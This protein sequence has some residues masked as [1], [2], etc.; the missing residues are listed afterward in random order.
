MILYESMKKIFVVFLLISLWGCDKTPESAKSQLKC[1]PD[2]GGL[3]LPDGFCALVVADHINFLRHI[4][5][6]RNGDIYGSRRNL[7]F[8]AGGLVGIRDLDDDGK[9]DVI[10][11]FGNEPGLGIAIYEGFLY[12]GTDKRI[13]KYALDKPDLVPAEDPEIV[14]DHFPD[15]KIH[16]GKTFAID[17][18]GLMYINVGS[19]SNACQ[20]KEMIPG[21]KGIDPCPD[22]KQ[23]AAI[24]RFNAKLVNQTFPTDGVKYATGIRNTY[25]IS[26]NPDNDTL[27]AV[28]HGRDGL[29]DLWPD[30][31]EAQQGAELPAEEFLMIKEKDIFGWPYCYYDPNKKQSKLAPEYGG[32]GQKTGR[33]ES[34]KA[35]V[36]AFPAH[37]SPNDLLF[38]SGDQFPQEFQK[39]AFIAFHGSYNRG[40][41]EQVGYQVV[42]VP[43]K[44]GLPTGKT[45]VFADGFSGSNLIKAPEDAEFRPGGLAQGPDGSL[46]IADSVQGRIWRIL[47]QANQN[48]E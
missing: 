25:A 28:Q 11:E 27:Y 5:V 24:W 20:E 32:D 8:E 38:Y 41:F 31:Y 42:Y 15:Q 40:P 36:L 9:A 44:D 16:A 34:F 45:Q 39:G 26:W 4:V 1:D 48:R 19:P 18:D 47:Y 37:Y 3:I 12:F 17:K 33:C 10:Q 30:I 29:Y 6:T 35:P 21:S 22:L 2:N 13:L 43:F 7:S 14:V 23:Q 46:Y